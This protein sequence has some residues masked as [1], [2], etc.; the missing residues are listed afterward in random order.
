MVYRSETHKAAEEAAG[1]FS[2]AAGAGDRQV[3]LLALA[4]MIELTAGRPLQEFDLYFW[5]KLQHDLAM[6]RIAQ[7]G[8]RITNSAIAQEIGLSRGTISLRVRSQR[9]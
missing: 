8:G 1:V 2:H 6:A 5:H 7:R 9:V 3:Q 4:N